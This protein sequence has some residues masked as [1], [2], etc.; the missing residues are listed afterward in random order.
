MPNIF[1][2]SDHHFG[3]ANILTFK[4]AD[5]EEPLRDFK[6]IEEH[7]YYIIE[8]HNSVVRPQDKVYFL[9]DVAM[10]HKHLYLLERMN[11]IKVLVKGN[12]D[13]HK[14]S[15]YTP[16]FKDIR[17]FH[18]F[19]GFALSHIPIHPESLGRWGVNIHGHL[20]YKRVLNSYRRPDPRYFNVSLECLDDYTPISLEQIKAALK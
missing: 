10:S 7:D 15:H 6:T 14:L 17:G 8:K 11:G 3:H 2:C 9:G 12:H 16:Y 20:H 5:S 19:D 13:I 1:L 18:Q 4:R